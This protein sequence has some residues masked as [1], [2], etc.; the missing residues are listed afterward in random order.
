MKLIKN[1]IRLNPVIYF[2]IA[3]AI[4]KGATH[5]ATDCDGN[6][7]YF[8]QKPNPRTTGPLAGVWI[9]R[10]QGGSSYPSRRCEQ[11]QLK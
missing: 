11:C 6:V 5:I 1:K 3:L 9:D 8:Y 10:K 2:G 7:E 4:P